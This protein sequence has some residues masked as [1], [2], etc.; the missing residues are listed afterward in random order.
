MTQFYALNVMH[1]LTLLCMKQIFILYKGHVAFCVTTAILL[2]NI[3]YAVIVGITDMIYLTL[4][5]VCV[6]SIDH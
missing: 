1:N 3:L 6:S 4:V 2:R 5:I